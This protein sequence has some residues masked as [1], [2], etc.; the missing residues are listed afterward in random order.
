MAALTAA[1]AIGGVA[2]GLSLL[3]TSTTA[4]SVNVGKQTVNSLIQSTNTVT[5]SCT[6]EGSQLQGQKVTC[7]TGATCN[8]NNNWNQTTNMNTACLQDSDVQNQLDSTSQQS[9]EQTAQS[10]TAAFALSTAQSKNYYQSTAQLTTIIDN[11]FVQNCTGYNTQYQFQDVEAAQGSTVNSYN[12]WSQ[13]NNSMTDCVSNNTAV[14]GVSQA[15]SQNLDQQ[16]KTKVTSFLGM[17]IS[18]IVVIIVIV[19]VFILLFFLIKEIKKSKAEKQKAAEPQNSN[20]NEEL[21]QLLLTAE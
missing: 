2:L 18:I 4:G 11:T 14:N 15:I 10:Q 17:I 12:D 9:A 20:V 8:V 1:L 3:G 7:G 19:V 5:S 13:Y 21:E 6:I 16:A